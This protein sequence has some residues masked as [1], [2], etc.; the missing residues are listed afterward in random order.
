MSMKL[1]RKGA[2][3][4]LEQDFQLKQTEEGTTEIGGKQKN[5]GFLLCN[6]FSKAKKA[7][8]EKDLW[9]EKV[10]LRNKESCRNAR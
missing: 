8:L 5:E 6:P 2:K 9:R 3:L 10:Q 1:T 4:S 7:S